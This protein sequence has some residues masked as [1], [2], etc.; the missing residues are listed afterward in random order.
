MAIE[1]VLMVKTLRFFPDIHSMKAVIMMDF[2]G[3]VA[4]F[5]AAAALFLV[6]IFDRVSDFSA[7]IT[8]DILE[9]VVGFRGGH[10]GGRGRLGGDVGGRDH[11]W[12]ELDMWRES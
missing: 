10:D 6:S 1:V 5:I 8:V 3:C 11:L 7:D 9:S 4:R 2:P 12:F